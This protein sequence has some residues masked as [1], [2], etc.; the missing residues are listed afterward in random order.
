MPGV[1]ALEAC[2]K[3][4]GFSLDLHNFDFASCDYYEKHGKML[5]D[6]WIDVLKPFDAILFGAVG[7]PK[8]CR[9]AVYSGVGSSHCFACD[10]SSGFPTT[11]VCGDRFS[12]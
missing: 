2:A 9:L 7:D 10:S 12:V 8:V 11:S 3:K 5:P 1:K 4:Y 6:D